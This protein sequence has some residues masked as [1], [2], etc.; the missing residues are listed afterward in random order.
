[1]EPAGVLII[2][3]CLWKTGFYGVRWGALCD[4]WLREPGVLDG[5]GYMKHPWC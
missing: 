2:F 3:P 1:M 4:N 5:V